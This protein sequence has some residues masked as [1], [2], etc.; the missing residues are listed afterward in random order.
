MSKLGKGG[1]IALTLGGMVLLVGA[2]AAMSGGKKK[3]KPEPKPQNIPPKPQTTP[4]PKAQPKPNNGP[5]IPKSN[6]YQQASDAIDQSVN[7]AEEFL[8]QSADYRSGVGGDKQAAVSA[9]DMVID[10]FG[11]L[12]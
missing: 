8:K 5:W 9:G 3:P 7:P 6:P 11:G 10:A 4:R 1:A 12:A 2:A